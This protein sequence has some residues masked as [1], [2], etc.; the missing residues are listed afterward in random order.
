MPTVVLV[1]GT[2]AGGWVWK[3]VA[4]H[5]RAAGQQFRVAPDD[6]ALAV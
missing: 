4:P 5:L 2:T 1:H 6:N 3:H